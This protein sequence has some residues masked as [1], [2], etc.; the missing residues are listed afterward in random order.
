MKKEVNTTAVGIV[1]FISLDKFL[2]LIATN[3]TDEKNTV[4]FNSLLSYGL[5]AKMNENGEGEDIAT[6]QRCITGFVSDKDGLKNSLITQ[7]KVCQKFNEGLQELMENITVE[8]IMEYGSPDYLVNIGPRMWVATTPSDFIIY[9]NKETGKKALACVAKGR[10]VINNILKTTE[11][12]SEDLA[13][14]WL[15]ISSP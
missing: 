5:P 7:A 10:L 14:K 11:K 1:D 4:I 12:E 3:P 15:S 6:Y 2:D 8:S 13:K 9:E